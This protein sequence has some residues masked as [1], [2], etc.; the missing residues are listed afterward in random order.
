ME[1]V[2]SPQFLRE[3]R[4]LAPEIKDRA[5]EKEKIFRNDPFDARLKTH[6][7]SGRLEGFLSF[8]VDYRH[9]II[10]KFYNSKIVR[11]YAIG[12]HSLYDKL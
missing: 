11:F 10:F 2:Y 4:R 3:Y 5:E 9:R 12:D 6:K 7:L 1:I 8:S